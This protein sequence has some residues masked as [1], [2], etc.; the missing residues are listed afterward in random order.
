VW[1]IG[2]GSRASVNQIITLLERIVGRKARVNYVEAQHGDT[3]HTWADVSAAHQELGYVAVT[4]LE[5]GL[6][7]QVAWQL[8]ST[9]EN[10]EMA[11]ET[12]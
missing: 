7:A 1:N 5:D 6:R 4:S 11:H 12:R 10:E 2:G 9:A 3:R 8:G